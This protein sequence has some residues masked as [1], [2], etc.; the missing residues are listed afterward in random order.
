MNWIEL[1]QER[2]QWWV[3]VNMM[4]HKRSVILRTFSV[5][6]LSVVETEPQAGKLCKIKQMKTTGAAATDRVT[7][8]SHILRLCTRRWGKQVTHH[9]L[10]PLWFFF[11]NQ[12]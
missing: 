2:D 10:P 1:A 5:R 3:V 6:S 9:P 11:K 7:R 8:S 4:N 12:N